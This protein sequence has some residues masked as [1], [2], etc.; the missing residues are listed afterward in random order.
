MSNIKAET[1]KNN[2]NTL[3]KVQKKHSDIQLCNHKEK[4]CPINGQCL[5]DSIVYQTNVSQYRSKH[6]WF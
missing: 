6:S 4:Q 5:T 3:E 1:H 2:K